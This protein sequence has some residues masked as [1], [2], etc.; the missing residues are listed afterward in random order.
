MLILL[1]L[2]IDQLVPERKNSTVIYRQ[3]MPLV[4]CGQ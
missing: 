3:D 2:Y 4:K 1:V